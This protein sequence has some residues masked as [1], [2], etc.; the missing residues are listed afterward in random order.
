MY[1]NKKR[2]SIKKR[3]KI[4]SGFF[5]IYFGGIF[6]GVLFSFVF[7]IAV[8]YW[9]ADGI[10]IYLSKEKILNV[11]GYEV[12]RQTQEEFPSF[13]KE[14]RSEVPSLVEKYM[15]ED[16]IRIGNLEI[17][18]YFVEL[19][20]QLMR[21]LE[22]DLRN[23]VIYYVH[24]LLDELEEEEFIGELSRSITEDVL[25]SL[26]LD[27]NG[28]TVSIPLTEHHSIPLRVWMQ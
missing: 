20:E 23:D 21:E 5:L 9:N 15:Q 2:N 27:L 3:K 1:L 16:F 17:G 14:V 24:E 28:R 6:T 19:P 25:D 18:G 22:K 12:E 26:F 4:L 10:N 8:I 13:I 11:I 7:I